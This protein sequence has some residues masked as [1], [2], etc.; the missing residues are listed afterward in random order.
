MTKYWPL[1]GQEGKGRFLTPVRWYKM[2]LYFPLNVHIKT[3]NLLTIQHLC[4]PPLPYLIVR[5]YQ[6][7]ILDPWRTMFLVTKLDET[8]S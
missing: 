2:D 4:P 5:D 1:I 8:D 3:P 7:I 6:R